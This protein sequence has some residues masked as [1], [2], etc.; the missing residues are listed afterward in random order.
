MTFIKSQDEWLYQLQHD[1]NVVARL[2]ALEQLEQETEDT[3][4]TIQALETCLIEDPF[5][6][7]REKAAYLLIDF[8]R[9]QSKQVLIEACRDIDSRVRTAAILALGYYYD[10]DLNSL[11]RSMAR[12][13]SSYKVIAEAIY[14]LSNVTDDSSF[15]FLS[16]YVDF[17]SHND[18]VRTAA[19]H[20]LR[21]IKDERSIPIAIQFVK[22]QTQPEYIRVNALSI[23][24]EVGSGHAEVEKAM[25]EILYDSN[26]FLKKK[27]I[28]V[29]GLFKT[30]TA[31][32]ALKKLRDHAL[33]DDVRRRLRISIEKIERRLGND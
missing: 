19:F 4:A 12:H 29:L 25:I 7:V 28:D 14:A 16:R 8:N 21:H 3:L 30:G 31:L 11:F 9:P 6:A 5:W 33:P 23:L 22:D 24:K 27:A 18:R 15:E 2:E 26:N 10:P 17:E 1:K 32:E 20:S 13:D